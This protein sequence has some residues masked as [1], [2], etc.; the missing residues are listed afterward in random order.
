[1]ILLI[2]YIT[3]FIIISAAIWIYLMPVIEAHKE[4]HPH[5]RAITVLALIG[6]WTFFGWIIAM[7]WAHT[8]RNDYYDN[9]GNG[10]IRYR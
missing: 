3:V 1:M 8:I 4:F 2:Q 5:R 10:P 6:G 9:M 7:V